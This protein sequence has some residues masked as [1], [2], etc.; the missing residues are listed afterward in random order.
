MSIA[1]NCTRIFLDHGGVS[2]NV[3]SPITNL[4]VKNM[5]KR[6]MSY[7]EDDVRV[8]FENWRENNRY[9]QVEWT[10]DKW[11][12]S[13]TL[14]K[15]IRRGEEDIAMNAAVHL[16]RID[17]WNLHRRLLT[18]AHEDIGMANV[19]AVS[20]VV[21][22]CASVSLRREL[23]ELHAYMF[24]VSLLS[25]ANK[26]R[27]TDQLYLIVNNDP[28]HEGVRDSL[29]EMDIEGLTDVAV[30]ESAHYVA[31]FYA[32]QKLFYGCMDDAFIALEQMGI[33]P[34][35]I[36]ACCISG[37]KL[38]IELPMFTPLVYGLF[39]DGAVVK[40]SSC[41][42]PHRLTNR[43]PLYAADPLHTRSG[44]RAVSLWR[45]AV[46]DLKPYTL[47]QIGKAVFHMH[48]GTTCVDELSSKPLDEI[49]HRGAQMSLY[50]GGLELDKQSSLI[51]AVKAHKCT[52][53]DVRTRELE[54]VRVQ[55]LNTARL[56]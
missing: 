32:L 24:A 17:K 14:Q 29:N 50:Q 16:Y 42:K 41:Y 36:D 46:P 23:N 53:K 11:L 51:D 21:C 45:D 34:P 49:K 44:K 25:R 5:M 33:A 43:L 27:V 18:I 4:K 15:A 2:A 39:F 35:L 20:L 1:I 12:I 47:K 56:I 52:F 19:C 3:N 28:K 8:E 7:L 26:S 6:D 10:Y 30:N 37:T 13:S 48:D 55:G 40:D 31:R 54:N 22:I 9:E 38:R